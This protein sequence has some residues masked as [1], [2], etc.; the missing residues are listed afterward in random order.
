[1]KL[2]LKDKHFELINLEFALLYSTP[3]CNIDTSNAL[4][5]C[6]GL[7]IYFFVIHNESVMI[8]PTFRFPLSKVYTIS[9]VESETNASAIAMTPV[10]TN[11]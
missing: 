5:I 2:P 10:S 11:F 4:R 6:R 7:A 8:R 1:M 3:Q 9:C